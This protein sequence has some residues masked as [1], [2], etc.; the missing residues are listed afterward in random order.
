MSVIDQRCFS[1]SVMV[2]VRTNKYDKQTTQTIL[3]PINVTQVAHWLE[4][5]NLMPV[6]VKKKYCHGGDPMISTKISIHY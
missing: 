5:D 1:F 6:W 4:W 3:N 2:L